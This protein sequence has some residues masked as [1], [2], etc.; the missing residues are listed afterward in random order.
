MIKRLLP[1]VAVGMISFI[2]SGYPKFDH[3]E[4]P[5]PTHQPKTIVQH[6]A[7][8]RNQTVYEI[9]VRQFTPQGTF[10]AI[11]PHLHELK[12]MGIKTIWLMPITPIG[13]KNRKGKLGSYYS[14]QNYL[15]VNP[16]YGTLSDFKHLVRSIHQLGM[17]VIIDWVADHTSWDNVLTKSHPEWY[18]HDKQGHF[19]PPVKDWT[20]VIALNYSK[21]GLRKY[22]INAMKYWVKE[23]NVDGF[24]CD[25]ASMVPINFWEEARR[26]LDQIKPVFMLAEAESPKMH[27]AFDMTYSWDTY[28]LFNDIAKGK[29]SA[30]AI[31]SVLD[32]ER[33]TYPADAYRMR[34][35]TNHDENSW[36]GT[37][38]ERLGK[39]AK[40]FAV[41]TF[42]IKGTPL[43]Y[44][45]QEVG[46]HKR[47]K[48]FQKDPINWNDPHHFREFYSRL[49]HLKLTNKALLSGSDGGKM[50]PVSDN[51]KHSVYA[52]TRSK[53]GNKVIVITNLSNKAQSV[54]LRSNSM[55]GTYHDLFS[56]KVVT[57]SNHVTLN[58]KPWEYKVYTK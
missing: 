3:Q 5:A 2:L 24:R 57:L 17:H 30:L 32:K 26:Q 10:N 20:D 21:P 55:K 51:K 58:L 11:I 45:G 37:V 16:N 25:V 36:N 7:W 1:L 53:D 27:K 15:K 14:V 28:H 38:F 34:F 48:F 44:D 9:N 47:L 18:K 43:I 52:F 31:D 13:K 22:M 29:R 8:T 33:S 4:K 40:A 54:E 50:K 23:T 41:L 6:P 35:I 39:G 12:R 49:V 19:V 42:T 56:G 46:M